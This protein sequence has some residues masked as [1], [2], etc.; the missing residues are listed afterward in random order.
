MPKPLLWAWAVTTAALYG[1]LAYGSYVTM[2]SLAGGMLGFDMRPL[3]MNAS[4]GATYMAA[5]TD[6]G[7]LYYLTWLKPLD[8]AFIAALVVLGVALSRTFDGRLLWMSVVAAL[9]YGVMD[10]AENQMVASLMKEAQGGSDPE[11]ALIAWATRSKFAAIA[12]MALTLLA[13]WRRSPR[14]G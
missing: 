2:P 11:F 14:H 12:V 7:R 8:T 3:G 5:M 9:V 4:D 1:V 10:L 6:A 13:Q